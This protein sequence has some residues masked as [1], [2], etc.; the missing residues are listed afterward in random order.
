MSDWK[1]NRQ[2]NFTIKT[3]LIL[4]FIVAASIAGY[5]FYTYQRHWN[6]I[7]A[8]LKRLDDAKSFDS[9]S[10]IYREAFQLAGDDM[11]PSMM[12]SRDPSVALQAKWESAKRSIAKQQEM[13]TGKKGNKAIAD[14]LEVFPDEFHVAV[15]DWWREIFEDPSV[16]YGQTYLSNSPATELFHNS[17]VY[18]ASCPKDA[19]IENVENELFYENE[20]SRIK[21]PSPDCFGE[22][23][24]SWWASVSAK[25]ERGIC[26]LTIQGFHASPNYLVAIDMETNKFLWLTE[27]CDG[28]G[29]NWTT[30]AKAGDSHI[31]VFGRRRDRLYAHGFNANDGTTL[32]RFSSGYTSGY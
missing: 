26:Y 10:T 7:K 28:G 19:T 1:V 24:H 21:I 9:I 12:N 8:V 17:N 30:I 15:P 14:F 5:R 20:E 22:Q 13:K 29:E 6:R 11:L 2:F 25:F 31:F 3:L 4:T 27:V 16:R 18:W 32:V 23:G